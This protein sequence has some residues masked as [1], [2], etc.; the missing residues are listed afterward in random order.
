MF[1]FDNDHIEVCP[2]GP[3]NKYVVPGSGN[4][5]APKRQQAI[6]RTYADPF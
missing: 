5:F 4:N 3:N 2:Y 1:E 6:V